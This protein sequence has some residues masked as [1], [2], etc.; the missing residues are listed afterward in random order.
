MNFRFVKIKDAIGE[1]NVNTRLDS[2]GN[3]YIV[4][5]DNFK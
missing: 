4:L 3:E 1:F 5:K 2:L